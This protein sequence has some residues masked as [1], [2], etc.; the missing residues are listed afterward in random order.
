MDEATIKSMAAELAKGLKTPEDLNQ[1]TAIFKGI[2]LAMNC[3][4]IQ[5]DDRLKD[6]L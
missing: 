4:T 6:H 1:M 2:S 3:F 5:F